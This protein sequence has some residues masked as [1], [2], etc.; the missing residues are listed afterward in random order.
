MELS[1]GS[2]Y[3]SVRTELLAFAIA[4][5]GIGSNGYSTLFLALLTVTL[6]LSLRAQCERN[7]ISSNVHTCDPTNPS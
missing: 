7:L 6:T 1:D 4:L 3:C 5:V 2:V